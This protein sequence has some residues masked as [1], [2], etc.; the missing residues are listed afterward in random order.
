[1]KDK[2][3]HKHNINKRTTSITQK[4]CMT[5]KTLNTTNQKQTNKQTNKQTTTKNNNR[6]NTHT[7]N[8]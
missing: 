5:N 7:H 1:M 6:N 4:T 2:Q 3:T 8:K